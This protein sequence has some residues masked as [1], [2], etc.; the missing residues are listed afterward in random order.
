MLEAAYTSEARYWLRPTPTAQARAVIEFLLN[1]HSLGLQP[2]DYC[3]DELHTA[4]A[5]LSVASPTEDQ[6]TFDRALSIAAVRLALHL[7][8]GRVTPAQAGFD[9]PTRATPFDSRELLVALSQANV[10]SEVFAR[11]EPQSELYRALQQALARYRGLAADPTLTQL[12]ALPRRSIKP[13][14]QYADAPRLRALLAAEGDLDGE[15][16]VEAA[17]VIDATLAEAIRRFQTRHG[18]EP[19]GIIGPGTY[20]ALTAPMAQRVRQIELTLERWRWLPPLRAP[21]IIIN[22][23]QFMLFALPRSA[24]EAPLELRVIVGQSERLRRTP[25]FSSAIEQVVFQPYWDIPRSILVNELLPL[26]ERD[27]KYLERHHME[28]V[29]GPTD[30]SPILPVTSANL[31]TL[32]AGG[33]R[34]R[35]R[36]GADNALGP[37]KFVL[38]NRYSVFL[39]GTPAAELFERSRRDF[40]HGCIRVSDPAALAFYV[41]RNAAETWSEQQIEAAMCGTPNQRVKLAQ[42][43]PVLI[44]Y[45]TVLATRQNGVMFFEDIYGHDRRLETLLRLTPVG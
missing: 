20:A 36:P 19:D 23:P 4:A 37:V 44:V 45:G 30:E 21:M 11:Y 42:P 12:A 8:R 29:A 16:S 33:A 13:G 34:L 26:I 39:H 5:H 1:T 22:V 28:I 27:P 41:L 32:K 6:T 10:P 3:A 25:L 9:L 15:A 17:E 38:P 14:E 40:S 43:L 35:Q 24:N 2:A 7:E 18:L 31:E